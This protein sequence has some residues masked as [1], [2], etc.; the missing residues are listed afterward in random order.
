MEGK[1]LVVEDDRRLAASLQTILSARGYDVH[2][3]SGGREAL[4]YARSTPVAAVLLDLGLPD[5]TGIEVATRLQE[6]H[7]DAAIIVLTGQAALDSAIQALRLGVYDYLEKPADPE[8]LLRI[9]ERG[10]EHK[11]LER[12]LKDSEQRF[13]QLSEATWEGIVLYEGGRALLANRQLCEMF[14]YREEELLGRKIFEFLLDQESI[15]VLGGTGNQAFGPFEAIG[16]RK[17]GS[18]F[19]VEIQVRTMDTSGKS[20]QVAALRDLTLRKEEERRRLALEQQLA[21]A[22]RMEALGLMAGSVAHDLNNILAGIVTYPELISLNMPRDFPFHQELEMIKDA[23]V[24]AA[25]VINDLLTVARGSTCKKV[26]RS[27]NA[28]VQSYLNSPEFKEISYR[29]PSV[30]VCAHLTE[31]ADDIA[32][33]P[34][35]VSR[36]LMNLVG[37]AIEAIGDRPGRV[38]LATRPYATASPV[39]LSH[40]TLAPGA[41]V[42]LIVEDDGPGIPASHLER[43][44][45]PFFTRKQ[46][47]RTGTGLGL[48]VVWNTMQQH[49]GTVDVASGPKGTRFTLYFPLCERTGQSEGSVLSPQAL[50]G[51]GETILV[52]DDQET[53]LEVARKS[54]QSLGY[55][56]YT[57]PSGEAAIEFIKRQEVD[58]V[59]LDMIM[60]PGLSGWETYE[61]M[62]AFSPSLKAVITSGYSAPGA[63]EQAKR[64]GIRYFLKK[65]YSLQELGQTLRVAMSAAA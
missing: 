51:H 29:Y 3:A 7:P 55:R 6:F 41:Y 30:E 46:W 19:P 36:T 28:L 4:E 62:L 11:R 32:C 65:P 54:L 10:I 26:V 40:D 20:V 47:N 53:Q 9:L 31:E 1:I 35:H 34:I 61:R 23:G 57:V 49:D 42:T 52:V 13:R 18:R 58:L 24:R 14:G 63:L 39:A 43:L 15:H 64:L 45:E 12:R 48:T 25:A 59:L 5:I 33:S 50:R 27:L 21:K 2:C 60:D 22:K 44:F 16:V 56:V 17:D 38:M 8:L 37:N